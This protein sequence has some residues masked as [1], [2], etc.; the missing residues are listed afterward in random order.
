MQDC[1]SEAQRNI[2]EIRM[3]PELLFHQKQG[4]L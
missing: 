2:H 3:T 1:R 4:F